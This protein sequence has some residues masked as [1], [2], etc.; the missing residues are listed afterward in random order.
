MFYTLSQLLDTRIM[1]KEVLFHFGYL[2]RPIPTDEYLREDKNSYDMKKI[3]NIIK[4]L[5][6]LLMRIS[7]EYLS[8]TY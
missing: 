8:N 4:F 7:L 2:E 1:P 5:V 3:E 6:Q